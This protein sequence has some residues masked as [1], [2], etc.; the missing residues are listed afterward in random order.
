MLKHQFES[1]KNQVLMLMPSNRQE[2]D[3]CIDLIKNVDY[4]N[5]LLRLPKDFK[6]FAKQRRKPKTPVAKEEPARI[7][8]KRRP[9][10]I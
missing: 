4:N 3:W 5:G 9:S 6:L 1:E 8:R 2:V 10:S 7:I